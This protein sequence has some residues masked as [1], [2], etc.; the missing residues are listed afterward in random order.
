[1]K[2]LKANP[3]HTFLGRKEGSER[4]ILNL[5]DPRHY[6]LRWG[7]QSGSLAGFTFLSDF[8][9]LICGGAG[10]EPESVVGT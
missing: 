2:C 10:I 8:F 4:R 7:C 5:R 3:R 9:T 1:M 6:L